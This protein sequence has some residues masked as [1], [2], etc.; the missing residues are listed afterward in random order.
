M[1]RCS[2]ENPSSFESLAQGIDYTMASLLEIRVD[3]G[4][5][6]RT[7]WLVM[8]RMPV[9]GIDVCEKRPRDL[10]NGCDGDRAGSTYQMAR[11]LNNRLWREGSGGRNEDMHSHEHRTYLGFVYG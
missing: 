5:C 2:L 10:N 6:F 4:V 8:E 9:L 7:V 3:N 11:E 1:S